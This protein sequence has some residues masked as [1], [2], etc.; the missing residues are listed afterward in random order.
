MSLLSD[1]TYGVVKSYGIKG[2][3]LTSPALETLAE[4]KD[5]DDLVNRL[6]GT[7]YAEFVTKLEKPFHPGDI[8]FTFRK[9]LSFVHNSLI[10]SMPNSDILR[11]YYMKYI[12]WN[13]KTILKGKALGKTYDE[14]I[15]YVDLYT[16][17]LIGRRDLVVKALA[18]K[19]LAESV[20][21]LKNSEFGEETQSALNIFIEKNN[22]QIFDTFI[23]KAF[24]SN[25][26]KTYKKK[27]KRGE[28]KTSQSIIAIDI[29]SYNIL[30]VLRAKTWQLST[31]QTR[32][33]IIEPIFNISIDTLDNMIELDSISQAVKLVEN[34]DYRTILQEAPTEKETISKLETAFQ[35]LSYQKAKRP[36]LWDIFSISTALGII[37]LKE[38]EIRNLS[39]ITFGVEQKIG[40]QRIIE[41]LITLK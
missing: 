20:E 1:K 4:A 13:L 39:S 36:F 12:S 11:A 17:E 8:D 34:T 26:I 37:K 22:V 27:L 18:T 19:N 10:K 16:E 3:L 15:R 23:D 9:H 14:I 41:K 7:I 5:L 2:T 32:D 35:I 38:L 30:A 6:R 21:I 28:R 31:S 29:D 33:L 25:I 24:F 40:A